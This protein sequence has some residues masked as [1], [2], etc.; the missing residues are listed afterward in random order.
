MILS[1]NTAVYFFN[2]LRLNIGGFFACGAFLLV[3]Y[4]MIILPSNACKDVFL[5]L[6]GLC[7]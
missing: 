3:S 6:S 2:K 7:T 1:E 4:S 5:V